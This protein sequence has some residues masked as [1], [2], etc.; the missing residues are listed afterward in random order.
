MI[1]EKIFH[2]FKTTKT[3]QN[4][5]N[6]AQQKKHKFYVVVFIMQIAN[7]SQKYR[8][9]HNLISDTSKIRSAIEM[10]ANKK[11]ISR[12]IFNQIFSFQN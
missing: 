1:N 3:N 6:K 9:S 11:V 7:Y 5:S 12:Q 10:K 4:S 8:N 2:L